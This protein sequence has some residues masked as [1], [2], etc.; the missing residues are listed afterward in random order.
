MDSRLNMIGRWPVPGPEARSKKQMFRVSPGETLDFIHGRENRVLVSLAVSNDFLHVGKMV[1]PAGACSDPE[2]HKGDEVLRGLSGTL[3][4][5]VV[6]KGEEEPVTTERFEVRTGERFFMP[7]GIRHKYFNFS[8]EICETVFS[9]A[10][11][12]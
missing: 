11:E 2:T 9:I 12:L 1:I 6:N 5:I 8:E 4:V 7:E 3:S 10:P